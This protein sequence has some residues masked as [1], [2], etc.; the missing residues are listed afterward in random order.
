[1]VLFQFVRCSQKRDIVFGLDFVIKLV[2][3]LPVGC[4]FIHGI[5]M[6]VG[7]GFVGPN[8]TGSLRI[9]GGS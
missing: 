5:R 3:G 8:S 9:R 2:N 4:F 7:G 6:C 1:M